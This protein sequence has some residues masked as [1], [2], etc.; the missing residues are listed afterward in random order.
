MVGSIFLECIDYSLFGLRFKTELYLM[1]R[2]GNFVSPGFFEVT[3]GDARERR[4]RRFGTIHCVHFAK[5]IG[6]GRVSVRSHRY[7]CLL[8]ERM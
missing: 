1:M 2:P 4:K 8:Y 5:E 6:T 7:I 3:L